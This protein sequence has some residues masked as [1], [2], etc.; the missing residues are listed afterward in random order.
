[1]VKKV[2]LCFGSIQFDPESELLINK[3]M[4]FN[5][6]FIYFITI[7]G[8][9]FHLVLQICR[10]RTED[11]LVCENEIIKRKKNWTYCYVY[12]RKRLL[13]FFLLWQLWIGPFII[14]AH[15]DVLFR[16]EKNAFSVSRLSRYAKMI[17]YST[18]F[19]ST[20]EIFQW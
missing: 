19:R 17:S 16:K 11:Q 7:C 3:F 20:T 1:M 2:F 10:S 8:K 13:H 4:G 6:H 12:V 5:F 15:V 9:I 14:F 18:S